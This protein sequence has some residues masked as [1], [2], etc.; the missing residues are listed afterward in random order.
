MGILSGKEEE[1]REDEHCCSRCA[2]TFQVHVASLRGP[3]SRG[4]KPTPRKG[5]EQVYNK[6]SLG[7]GTSA[8][9]ELYR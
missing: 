9:Y 8:R 6:P 5:N 2:G 4:G 7:T 1:Y 3:S